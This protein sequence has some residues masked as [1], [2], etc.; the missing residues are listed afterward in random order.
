MPN[1][2]PL[3]NK[4]EHDS[5]LAIVA[6]FPNG[7][8]DARLISEEQANQPFYIINAADNLYDPVNIKHFD[9]SVLGVVVQ[10]KING[11]GQN[12]FSLYLASREDEYGYTWDQKILAGDIVVIQLQRPRVDTALKTI[13][14]GLVKSV[15]RP[16]ELSGNPDSPSVNRSIEIKGLDMTWWLMKHQIF[17]D[18]SFLSINN[19]FS[20]ISDTKIATVSPQ[21]WEKEVWD[22][23][24][25]FTSIDQNIASLFTNYI[26]VDMGHLPQDSRIIGNNVKSM[27]DLLD[28]DA[29]ASM[30]FFVEQWSVNKDA[31]K[32]STLAYTNSRGS[33]GEFILDLL[34]RPFNEICV[35][36]TADDKTCTN[37]KAVVTVRPA[38]YY[39]DVNNPIT[40]ITTTKG[41]IGAPLLPTDF[42]VD[43][44][45]SDPNKMSYEY[46]KYNTV[47]RYSSN[48]SLQWK[49]NVH[50]I[51][52]LDVINES[53][54]IADEGTP[55]VFL[56]SPKNTESAIG[57]MNQLNN[58]PQADISYIHRFGFN[59]LV[60]LVDYVGISTTSTDLK[61]PNDL[62]AANVTFSDVVSNVLK[63][64]FVRTPDYKVGKI[65]I[66]GRASIN[67][68][69]VLIFFCE[70]RDEVFLFSIDSVT[71]TFINFVKF[72]TVLDVSRGVRLR[73]I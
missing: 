29:R 14:V 37:P 25:S 11:F 73:D 20:Q 69:D 18:L 10:K 65:T 39:F 21:L 68:G 9:T 13:M 71:H 23:I 70:E 45:L 36:Y 19:Y 43:T 61:D 33:I 44:I 67:E 38:P 62:D 12:G 64:W 27:A 48:L 15:S 7:T 8:S 2:W 31:F 49:I 59:P 22:D 16:T 60:F 50:V 51:N 3:K 72:E 57:V 28:F 42:N 41:N 54:G 53:L 32:V 66:K 35:T 46:S 1:Y 63:Q 55:T 34:Q 17:S 26:K 47:A 30:A 6:I 24:D 52:D 58:H 4:V 56:C 40:Q 5:P